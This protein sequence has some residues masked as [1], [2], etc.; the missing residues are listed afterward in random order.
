MEL[1]E[2]ETVWNNPFY[3]QELEDGYQEKTSAST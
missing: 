1:T 2:E 3:L